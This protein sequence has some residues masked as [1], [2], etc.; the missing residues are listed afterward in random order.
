M[1]E[2]KKIKYKGELDLNGMTIPCYVLEDGTRI[3]SGRG[4]QEALK[5]TDAE[6]GKQTSGT[7]LA[8]YL[9]QKND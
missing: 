1:E 9:N 7:R 4:L 8:R 2:K 3:L 5:M 6:E